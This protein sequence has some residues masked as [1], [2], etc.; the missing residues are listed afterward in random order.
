[1]KHRLPIA[2]LLA[3]ATGQA[4][5]LPDSPLLRAGDNVDIYFTARARA[6]YNSNLFYNSASSLPKN[7]ASWIIGPGLSAD[8]FKEANFSGSVSWHHDYVRFFDSALKGLND[9][10]D[11][12][13]ATLNYDGGGPLTFHFDA[14][15]QEDAR[16][17]PEIAVLS[18]SGTLIRNTTYSQSASFGYRAT[19]KINLSFAA[20]H[21]S[22]RYGPSP[23]SLGPPVVY[24]TQGLTETDGWTFPL[25][26]R[27]QARERLSIGFAFEHGASDISQ[28]RGSD[29]PLVYTSSAKDFYGLT[30]SGQPTSSG[31]LDV[32]LKAGV[33][34]SSLEGGTGGFAS[35]TGFSYSATLTHTLTEK[36]NHSL[37]LGDAD[38]VGVNGQLSNSR[39]ANYAINYVMDDAFRASAFIGLYNSDV[40]SGT[41]TR[42]I[43]T[44][45][46]GL[47]ATYSP[48]SHWTYTASYT[49]TQSYIPSSYN[50]H[51]FSLEANL[52]W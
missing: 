13:G 51:A 5:W 49:L 16:N 24:N 38:N 50:V 37:S 21:S 41:V 12:G 23:V 30:L 29:A 46:Y 18:P 10:R 28:A 26:I 15:Y 45:S 4:G 14:S 48:E 40:D 7:G 27:Y 33:S 22:N 44:G 11:V 20:T 31:K 32:V 2:I 43:R 52:R 8:F 36:I 3:A 19:E 25:N 42:S 6:D 39:N 34:R 35:H 47:S 9:E 1:M 17:S